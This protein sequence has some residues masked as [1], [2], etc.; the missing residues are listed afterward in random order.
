MTRTMR[1]K[2][3]TTT[4]TMMTT[5]MMMRKTKSRTS[6]LI[7]SLTL[8]RI[9]RRLVVVKIIIMAIR[10]NNQKDCHNTFIP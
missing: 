7:R 6:V 5:K 10:E 1:M 9:Q 3:T 8:V 4:T 2:T